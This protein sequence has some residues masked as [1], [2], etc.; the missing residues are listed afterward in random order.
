[1]KVYMFR[2]QKWKKISPGEKVSY[3]TIYS[4]YANK[5]HDLISKKIAL[6]DLS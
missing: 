2:G 5:M 3:M 1:M 6:W 4:V